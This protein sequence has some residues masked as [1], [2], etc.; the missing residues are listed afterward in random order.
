MSG[1]QSLMF[2][3][4]ESNQLI[5]DLFIRVQR[6]EEKLKIE[7]RNTK[8]MNANIEVIKQVKV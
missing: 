5:S 4:D 8:G 3:I 6:A 1:L 7:N 2:M